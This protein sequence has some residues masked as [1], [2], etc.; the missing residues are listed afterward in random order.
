MVVEQERQIETARAGDDPGYDAST[1]NRQNAEE[2]PMAAQDEWTMAALAHASVLLALVLGL[3][4]GVGAVIG[5][6]VALAVYLA[7]RRRSRL[8][9]YHAMQALAYQV[10]CLL[11]YGG[12]VAVLV[13]SVAAAWTVSGLL[14]AVLIGFLLMPLAA[15]LTLL[16]IAVLLGAPLAGVVY[17]LYAAYQVYQGSP[18]MYWLIGDWVERETKR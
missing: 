17:G 11:A 6:A 1:L 5:P 9:A 18:F 2:R 3:S 16:L 14:S 10:A 13:A 7:Y 8:V 15:L 12:L 4:G